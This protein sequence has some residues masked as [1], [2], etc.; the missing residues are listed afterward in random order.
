MTM[1]WKRPLPV[2]T[3]SLYLDVDYEQAIESVQYGHHDNATPCCIE[4]FPTRDGQGTAVYT[5]FD[6][7]QARCC[8]ELTESISTSSLTVAIRETRDA[9]A[10]FVG[11]RCHA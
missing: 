10:A 7:Q 8:F 1:P 6:Y 4:A 3:I 11:V 9:P 5:D 2:R